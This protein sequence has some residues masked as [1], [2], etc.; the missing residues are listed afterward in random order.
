MRAKSVFNKAYCFDFDETLVITPAKIHIYKNNVYNRSITSKGFN[1]YV[2]QSGDKLDFSEFNNGDLILNAKKYKCWP[3]IKNVSK[4]IKQN[5]STSEI[6]ILTARI[7]QVKSYI[8]EF[9]KKNGV[10][11]E[12][13]SILT[14][15]DGIGKINISEEKHK[16]LTNLANKYDEVLFFDDNIKN[17]NMAKT[18]PKVK[19]RLIENNITNE[20]MP[21]L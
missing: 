20:K 18:I 14:I 2:Y 9:L 19:T 6:F 17:I 7:P 4:A 15:G 1:S 12:L 11:I 10:E 13:N 21:V 5:K 3:I 8:Y 16:I